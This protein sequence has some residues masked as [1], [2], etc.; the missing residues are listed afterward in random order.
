LH[1]FAK[2]AVVFLITSL[3][4]LVLFP[5]VLSALELSVPKA[6]VGSVLAGASLLNTSNGRRYSLMGIL[7]FCFPLSVF[8]YF[9]S[10]ML[11]FWTYS[12]RVSL[13]RL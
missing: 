2:L 6:L 13:P 10:P 7:A 9:F 1:W 12:N 5:D 3:S 8:L 11:R 4:V